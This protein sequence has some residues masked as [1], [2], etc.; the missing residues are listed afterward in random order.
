[1]E[2]MIDPKTLDKFEEILSRA[3]QSADSDN[4]LDLVQAMGQCE[5]LVEVLPLRERASE[6]MTKVLLKMLKNLAEG[7]DK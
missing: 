4:P 7:L 2:Q 6:V 5:V 1:M 3:E